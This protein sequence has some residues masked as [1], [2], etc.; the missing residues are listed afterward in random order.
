MSTCSVCGGTG[1]ESSGVCHCGEEMDSKGIFAHSGHTPVE[2]TRPCEACMKQPCQICQG[3]PSR[4]ISELAKLYALAQEAR[5]EAEEALSS[6]KLEL[7][8]TKRRL[9]DA[10][11]GEWTKVQGG[12]PLSQAESVLLALHPR[13]ITHSTSCFQFR[14]GGPCDCPKAGADSVI[15]DLKRRL[16]ETKK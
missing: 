12:T 9:A 14:T 4:Q 16:P 8:E 1:V 2:M 3:D 11:K 5:R 10:L 15:S 6:C 7:S 13:C